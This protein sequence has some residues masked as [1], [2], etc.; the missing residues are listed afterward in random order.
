MSSTVCYQR[1]AGLAPRARSS[2][3]N[4]YGSATVAEALLRDMGARSGFANKDEVPITQ[5]RVPLRKLLK[6]Y[7][8]RPRN[9]G[10]REFAFGADVDDLSLLAGLK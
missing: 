1:Q 4:G 10:C 6:G 9:M 3:K 2:I 7:A 8:F 5:I